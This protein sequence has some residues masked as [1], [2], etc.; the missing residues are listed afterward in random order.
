M[1][2]KRNDI[3]S[4]VN[5]VFFWEYLMGYN[6]DGNYNKKCFRDT[7]FYKLLECKLRYDLIHTCF[8]SYFN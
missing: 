4:V 3:K 7:N 8:V 2:K 6:F 5:K 1:I